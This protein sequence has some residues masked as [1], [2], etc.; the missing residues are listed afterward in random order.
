MANVVVIGAQWGDEG[1]GKIT[2][3][4]SR[5]ADIVVRYQGGVNAGH[6]IVVDNKV[7]KLHLIPSGILYKDTTCLIGSGTV[8][9]P[10]VLLREIDM[11]RDNGIDISGLK[12]SATSHVTMPYHRLLDEAMENE[13]GIQKI[14]TTGRGIGPTYADKSQR[15]GVRVR[16]LLDKERLKDVLEI[17]LKEKNGLLEKIYNIKPLKASEI[18]EE[19]LEYGERLKQHVVD[20][21]RTIH[22]ASVNKKNILFEGAQ[23][24]LLDLDHGTYPYVTSSNPISGGA[25]VGAGVGPTLIDRVIG[26]AKA[27]TTRVG[28]GPFPT[29]LQGS[30][31]DQLCDRGGEF[32]TTT[33]R[34]RRCG[35]FDGIIGKYAVQVNGLDCLAITKL[36]VLDELDE[37]QVCT[38]YELNG[39][40]IDYF[41]TNADDLKR[42][43]PIFK[44]LAGWQCS[45]A[46]C[47][48]LSDL[49]KGAMNYLRFLAELMEVPI[50][51][52]SL[53]ANRDQT[54]VIEDPIH[55]PKRALLR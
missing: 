31:N 22:S 53:G 54:I 27:Y 16:D 30:I 21:T 24:T 36:D 51:I 1:K 28:E 15:N 2:D 4:L 8:V 14:G 19:Y 49:P 12:L 3:L 18:L 43:K 40:R 7:L 37:I 44:K 39:K 41:P 46:D 33:G 35:W 29:E 26:V 25:C 11:L 32:G 6:T 20:C 13:R 55:G 50:A 34:R 38:A 47:R 5:S 10:K 17:P 52:V 9:D 23:G 48:K 45:T 42:C